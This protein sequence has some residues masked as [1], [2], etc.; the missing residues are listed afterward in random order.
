MSS[1][2]WPAVAVTISLLLAGCSAS[3]PPPGPSDGLPV[4]PWVG[5]TPLPPL[6][7]GEPDLDPTIIASADPRNTARPLDAYAPTDEATRLVNRARIIVG[8]RCMARFGFQ[9]E[10]GWQPEGTAPLRTWARYGLWD[11]A[12]A[13]EHGYMPPPDPNQM[14][15][16]PIRFMES[17][18]AINVYLGDVTQYAGQEVPP[19][20][21]QGEE[22]RAVFGSESE[23]AQSGYVADLDREALIRAA[24]DS[25]VVPLMDAWRECVKAAG[26]EYADV[27]APF[28]YWSTRRGEDKWVTVISEEEKQSARADIQCKTSTG[29]LG[30]WLAADIAYQNAI[31]EREGERLREWAQAIDRR[32]GRANEILAEG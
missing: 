8:D 15:N 23:L 4:M 29:L 18:D 7:G 30:T 26:W 2:R 17:Q 28:A 21:C 16:P 22:L 13:E 20:G 32:V 11:P 12:P 5:A 14:T 27:M 31:I 24:Q 6:A 10:P 1:V 3:D 19:G 25:R 9:P